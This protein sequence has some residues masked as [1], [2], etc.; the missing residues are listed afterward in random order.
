[1]ADAVQVI[2]RLHRRLAD[3]Q[4]QLQDDI[5]GGLPSWDEYLKMTARLNEVRRAQQELSDLTKE[6]EL[7]EENDHE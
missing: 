5:T 6:P 4:E 3:R 1:M 2:Y 7:D